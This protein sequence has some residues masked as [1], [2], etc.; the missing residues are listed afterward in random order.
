MSQRER[1][2]WGFTYHLNRQRGGGQRAPVEK[3]S[4]F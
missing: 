3:T 2:N 1:Q 4:D